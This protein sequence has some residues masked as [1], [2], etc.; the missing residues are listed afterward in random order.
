LAD[1]FSPNNVSRL[2]V[3]PQLNRPDRRKFAIFL[4]CASAIALRELREP[5]RRCARYRICLTAKVLDF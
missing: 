2:E 5:L 1:C 3:D 4:S